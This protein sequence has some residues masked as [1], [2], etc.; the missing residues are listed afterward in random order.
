MAQDEG[1]CPDELEA[2]HPV[3]YRNFCKNLAFE[4]GQRALNHV[5]LQ[6]WNPILKPKKYKQANLF[7][8]WAPAGK[9]PRQEAVQNAG[10]LPDHKLKW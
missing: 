7:G 5:A 1:F 6:P 3:L 10:N 4:G 2:G 9:I 8:K